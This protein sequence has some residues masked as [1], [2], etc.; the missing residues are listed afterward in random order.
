MRK[1]RKLLAALLTVAML[2]GLTACGGDGGQVSQT[3]TVAAT[4]WQTVGDIGSL[5]L[6][7][8]ETNGDY[9]VQIPQFKD[10]DGND[11]LTDMNARLQQ[12]A[13]DYEAS[14]TI[15]GLNW[16]VR[17]MV[18]ETANY[19]SVVLHKQELPAYGT[20]GEASSYVYDKLTKEE[21]S[22]ELA[23]SLAGA[24]DDGVA[25][26]LVNYCNDVLDKDGQD[27]RWLSFNTEGYYMDADGKMALVLN[28]SIKPR[29]EETESWDYLLVYKGGQIVERFQ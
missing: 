4:E 10:A 8:D 5:N 18:V 7:V 29:G 24:T 14:K 25:E 28:A 23:W 20:D 3:G 26:A 12:L 6:I 9:T 15:D 11:V 27:W 16:D 19:L 21:V 17:P 1:M 13:A 2:M 22:E